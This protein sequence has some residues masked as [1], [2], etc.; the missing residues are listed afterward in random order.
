MKIC[1]TCFFVRPLIGFAEF[2]IT[3]DA[4]IGDDR[5][6]HVLALGR[7]GADFGSLGATARHADLRR[8]IDDR[9]D[10]GGRTF[11]GDVEGGAGMLRFELFGELRNQFRAERVGAFDDEA[12]G[13]CA[14]TAVAASNARLTARCLIFIALMV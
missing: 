10:P 2:T 4:V 7:S 1:S 9:G 6:L 8:A 13:V 11:G 14:G 3:A 5:W 12:I